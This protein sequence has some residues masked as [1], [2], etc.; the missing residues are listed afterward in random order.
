MKRTEAVKIIT[1]LLR[2]QYNDALKY[3]V[4]LHFNANEILKLIE[5]IGMAPPTDIN[6]QDAY[7]NAPRKWDSE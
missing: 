1:D 3:E 4:R 7:G 6:K 5:D 2:R